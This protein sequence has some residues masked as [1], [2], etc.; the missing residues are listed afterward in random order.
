MDAFHVY[1]GAWAL[2]CFHN[3]ISTQAFPRALTASVD[4]QLREDKECPFSGL[5]SSGRVWRKVP[6]SNARSV[7]DSVQLGHVELHAPPVIVFR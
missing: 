7:V 5:T 1:V 3:H 6:E 4:M 2:G